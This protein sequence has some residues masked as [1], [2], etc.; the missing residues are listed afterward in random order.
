MSAIHSV[1]AAFN[2]LASR[3]QAFGRPAFY[4]GDCE[5]WE[6]CG[7]PPSVNSSSGRRNWKE[8][9]RGAADERGGGRPT[10]AHNRHGR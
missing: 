2:K 1:M 4:C 8:M 5:R 10:W 3:I 9:A 7:Q 6:R